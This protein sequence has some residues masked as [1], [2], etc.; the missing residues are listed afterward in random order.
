M[1][2]KGRDSSRKP[3]PKPWVAFRFPGVA[4]GVSSGVAC[5]CLMCEIEILAADLTHIHTHNSAR[6]SRCPTL[7]QLLRRL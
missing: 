1:E 5:K 6:A 4:E 7:T 3:Q 2:G